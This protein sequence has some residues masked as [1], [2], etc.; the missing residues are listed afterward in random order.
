MDPGESKIDA[1]LR[2]CR[3]ETGLDLSAYRAQLVDLGERSYNKKRGKRLHLFELGLPEALS[4]EACHCSSWVQRRG[5]AMPEMDAWAWVDPQHVA[6]LVKP[7]MAKHL[8]K[9]GLL[10]QP[11][12]ATAKPHLRTTSPRL[13]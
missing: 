3:E 9:R 7:R 4:L 8:R 2:E 12:A 6:A 5:V 11:L 1:A 13:G 10:P